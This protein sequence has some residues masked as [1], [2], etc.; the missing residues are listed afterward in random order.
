M[1]L[2]DSSGACVHDSVIHYTMDIQF[3]SDVK[4]ICRLC[5]LIHKKLQGKKKETPKMWSNLL[6]PNASHFG[7]HCP[8]YL[9]PK[10]SRGVWFKTIKELKKLSKNTCSRE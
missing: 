4:F 5:F 6:S 1:H 3:F 8:P 9:E 10:V 7:F 2:M